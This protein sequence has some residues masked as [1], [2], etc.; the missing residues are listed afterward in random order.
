[1][2]LLFQAGLRCPA[3]GNLSTRSIPNTHFDGAVDVVDVDVGS[4]DVSI[5]K[6]VRQ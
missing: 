3:R 6:D 2:L 1:M 5:G 4:V